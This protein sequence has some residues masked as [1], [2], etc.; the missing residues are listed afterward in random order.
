M[1]K[2]S[3]LTSYFQS[4][5]EQA[6]ENLKGNRAMLPVNA[7]YLILFLHML[8]FIFRFLV[9]LYPLQYCFISMAQSILFI[10]SIR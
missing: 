8:H 9:S 1:S 7:G 2:T 3:F 4:I 5:R 10:T 6:A